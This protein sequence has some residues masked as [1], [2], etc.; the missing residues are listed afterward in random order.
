MKELQ[1]TVAFRAYNTI[2]N[3][4]ASKS[5]KTLQADIHNLYFGDASN[6]DSIGYAEQLLKGIGAFGPMFEKNEDNGNGQVSL[7]MKRVYHHMSDNIKVSMVPSDDG[8]TRRV[9][10][11]KSLNNLAQLSPRT[12]W[13]FAKDVE[14]NGKKALA[15]VLQSE[16]SEYVKTGLPPSGKTY[17]DYLLFI[18]EAMFKEL[19]SSVIDIE[20]DDDTSAAASAEGDAAVHDTKSMKE[21]W[22][23]PGFLSFALWGPIVPD[24]MDEIHKAEAFFP[25]DKKEKDE[26]NSGRKAA[27]DIKKVEDTSR[28]LSSSIRKS[29]PTC[30]SLSAG[31][32]SQ[33]LLAASIAQQKWMSNMIDV[34]KT[35]E[36]KLTTFQNK[37]MRAEREVDRWKSFITPEV[38]LDHDNYFFSQFQ[39]A[40]TKLHQAE[41]DLDKFVAEIETIKKQNMHEN[42]VQDIMND[43]FLQVK[44]DTNDNQITP[45]VNKR[46]RSETP[47]SS[48]EII[49]GDKDIDKEDNLSET[50][51]SIA[52]V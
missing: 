39:M 46:K 42:N 48:I 33:Y 6:P 2:L 50:Y 45:Q 35:I 18:R 4:G 14:R 16:Y 21:S 11:S 43:A 10:A 17:D 12:I 40:N 47:M 9:L 32:N 8:I 26:R 34:N 52:R 38:M 49:M 3:S 41:A 13:D 24:G 15:L 27:R 37:V 22:F 19:S 44:C 29:P 31:P 7:T 36:F 1:R 51:D 25:A 28:S 20:D 30:T 23:F 5:V